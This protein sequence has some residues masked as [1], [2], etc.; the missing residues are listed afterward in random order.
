MAGR[1]GG[2]GHEIEM[3]GREGRGKKREREDHIPTARL[4]QSREGR[5]LEGRREWRGVGFVFQR[6]TAQS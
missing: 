2:S 6:S 1:L 4:W 5:V 3:G